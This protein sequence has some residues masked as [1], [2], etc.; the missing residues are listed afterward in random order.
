[1]ERIPVNS[2][3]IVSIGYDQATITLEI[4]FIQGDVYQYFD[5]PDVVYQEFISAESHGKYFH[6]NIKDNYRCVKL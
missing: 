3:A 1:M 6:A 4:A 2:S 5:V